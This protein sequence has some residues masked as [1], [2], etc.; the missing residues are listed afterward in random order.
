M[1][2]LQ[3]IQSQQS[4]EKV[5]EPTSFGIP[6]TKMSKPSQ[7]GSEPKAPTILLSKGSLYSR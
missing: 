5:F 2:Y 7:K 3:Y 6:M 1:G 4:E